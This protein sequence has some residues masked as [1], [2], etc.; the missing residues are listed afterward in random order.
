LVN[1]KTLMYISNKTSYNII[2]KTKMT[3]MSKKFNCII[4]ILN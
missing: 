1:D 4:E 3:Y 2:D